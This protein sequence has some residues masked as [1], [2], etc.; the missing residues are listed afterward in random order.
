MVLYSMQSVKVRGD[1][2]D[3]C[4]IFME[5]PS[6]VELPYY[7]EVIKQP[8]ALDKILNNVLDDQYRSL[9][10]MVED[11]ELMFKNAHTFNEPGSQVYEDASV[12]KEKVA[13]AVRMIDSAVVPSPTELT[14]ATM[15]G[16][17]PADAPADSS[18]AA[19]AA[20]SADNSNSNADKSASSP[21]KMD[22]GG[23]G[24]DASKLSKGEEA[25]AARRARS[26]ELEKKRQDILNL[27]EEAFV[28]PINVCVRGLFDHQRSSTPSPPRSHPSFH[29]TTSSTPTQDLRQGIQEESR[30]YRMEMLGRDR[31]RNYYFLF[32]NVPGILIKRYEELSVREAALEETRDA[33]PTLEPNGYA[34]RMKKIADATAGVVEMPVDSQPGAA[35]A[36]DAAAAAAAAAQSTP[37][38]QKLISK[39][40][41]R[42]AELQRQE[43]GVGGKGVRVGGG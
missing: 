42:A 1:D 14:E 29:P 30:P 4:G 41:R 12:L 32:N 7:Y 15:P 28:G 2:Y 40:S 19:A 18:T 6:R 36:G 5:L 23:D 25:V 24:A 17:A 20:A 11:L 10:A 21:V 39:A 9:A 34:E 8:I 3:I 22:E 16:E 38:M 35:P 37:A 26:E 43:V 31:H 13:E 33:R 27:V